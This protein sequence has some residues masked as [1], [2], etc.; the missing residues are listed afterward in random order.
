[1]LGALAL[2][3]L[4]YGADTVVKHRHVTP[5][6]VSSGIWASVQPA[7]KDVLERL[8]DGEDSRGAA[9]LV[10]YD[11]LRTSSEIDQHRAD[12]VRV[13]ANTH[14]VQAGDYKVVE[15]SYS[16]SFV[17]YDPHCYVVAV[18]IA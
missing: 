6:P 16:P 3:R 5:S 8:P 18:R 7:P 2:T 9:V 17:G 11:E 4:R 12:V 1:M 15:V 14:G 13:P 10:T